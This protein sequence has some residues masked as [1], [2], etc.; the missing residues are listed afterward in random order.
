MFRTWPERRQ[1]GEVFSP[2]GVV[3]LPEV[4][5][6][7]RELCDGEVA[8]VLQA[9]RIPGYITGPFHCRLS[10]YERETNNLSTE[11]N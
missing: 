5:L 4:H 9:E 7:V 8:Q 2:E 1:P 3:I 11:E 6:H 10:G